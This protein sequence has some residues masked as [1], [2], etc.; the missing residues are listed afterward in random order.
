MHPLPFGHQGG[1]TSSQL[2]Q[3]VGLHKR[4]MRSKRDFD[5]EYAECASFRICQQLV[6]M[7]LLSVPL[8]SDGRPDQEPLNVPERHPIVNVCPISRFRSVRP[9]SLSCDSCRFLRPPVLLIAVPTA[10]VGLSLSQHQRHG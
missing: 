7:L 4:T 6:T 3:A 2:D 1:C 8:E 10:P 5:P 9:L